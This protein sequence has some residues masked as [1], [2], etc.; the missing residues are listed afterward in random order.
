MT[1]SVGGGIAR[2]DG[3]DDRIAA[4]DGSIVKFPVALA[5]SSCLTVQIN[6]IRIKH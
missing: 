4:V 1:L 5:F 3:S 6:K 2:M